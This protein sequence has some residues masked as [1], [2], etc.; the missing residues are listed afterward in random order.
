MGAR[1]RLCIRCSEA[2]VS[3]WTYTSM[4]PSPPPQPNPAMEDRIGR[5]ETMMVNMMAMIREMQTN[6]LI[7]GP[8]KPTASTTA[9]HNLRQT[10]WSRTTMIW[11]ALMRRV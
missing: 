10:P 3:I 8:S 11:T 7:V 4:S 1:T 2:H 9:Q 6:S 5:L